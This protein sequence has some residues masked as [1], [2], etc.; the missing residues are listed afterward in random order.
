MQCGKGQSVTAAEGTPIA[1]FRLRILVADGDQDWLHVKGCEPRLLASFGSKRTAEW[2][3]VPTLNELGYETV[4]DSP[5]DLGGPAGIDPAVVQVL[6]DAFREALDDAEVREMLERFDMPATYMDSE[7]YTRFARRSRESERTL[8][9]RLGLAGPFRASRRRRQAPHLDSSVSW[10][11]SRHV[12]R[13]HVRGR[14][15][16]LRLRSVAMHARPRRPRKC[17]GHSPEARTVGMRVHEQLGLLRVPDLEHV[18]ER[19]H[20]VGIEPV[21]D[22]GLLLR[23]S[24]G[25]FNP[26]AKRRCL[27]RDAFDLTC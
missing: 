12:P 1:R 9:E 6:H 8:I 14:Q 2:P 4:S 18:F 3:N 11:E 20:L 15:S 23:C 19:V 10:P 13:P 7:E 25:R 17:A 16:A 22:Q 27:D 24:L 21:A 26:L 5:S